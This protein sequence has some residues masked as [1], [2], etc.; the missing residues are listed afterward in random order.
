ME[1]NVEL[2]IRVSKQNLGVYVM[3][4][5]IC[6]KSA[7]NAAGL[8]TRLSNMLI[9]IFVELAAARSLEKSL[10]QN[11]ANGIWSDSDSNTGK[12]TQIPGKGSLQSVSEHWGGERTVVETQQK[13]WICGWCSA[14]NITTSS[15]KNGEI[16]WCESCGEISQ[17]IDQTESFVRVDLPNMVR[18]ERNKQKRCECEV[19]VISID[20]KN[21]IVECVKCN[22][23]LDPFDALRRVAENH[24]TMKRNLDSLRQQ[25]KELVNYKPW[26]RVIKKLEERYRGH[27]MLPKCPHCNQAF[28][29]EEIEL[30]SSEVHVKELRRQNKPP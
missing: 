1:E 22:A 17:V 12:I 7:K 26:L 14:L 29:L 24:E 4:S 21:H 9:A 19:P 27:K 18:I 16:V 15:K 13:Q 11:G 20:T 23:V 10:M 5:P 6:S 8:Y 30:W 2:I 28:Y 25:Q 3:D